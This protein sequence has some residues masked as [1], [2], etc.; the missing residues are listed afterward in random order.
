[1]LE[2]VRGLG[3]CP[4]GKEINMNTIETRRAALVATLMVLGIA[5]LA[6]DLHRTIIRWAWPLWLG[7]WDTYIAF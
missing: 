2:R 3:P 6:G 1:M 4:K 5:V 7:F